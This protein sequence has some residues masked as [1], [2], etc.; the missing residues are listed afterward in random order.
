MSETTFVIHT[1]HRGR[2]IQILLGSLFAV[3]IGASY[4]H[5]EEIPKIIGLLVCLPLLLFLSVKWSQQ[6]STWSTHAGLLRIV[7]GSKTWEFDLKDITHI[8]NHLRSGGNL[9]AIHKKKKF[10]PVRFWRNKLFQSVDEM[11]EMLR[12]LESLGVPVTLA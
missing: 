2:F 11:T 10:Q 4:I 8:Q 1:L 6:P 12:H 5:V 3:G 7:K 9:L